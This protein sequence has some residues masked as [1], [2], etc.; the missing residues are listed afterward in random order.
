V[1]QT[2]A[3][4]SERLL[5]PDAAA[6]VLD[7]LA[8]DGEAEAGPLRLVPHEV[9]DLAEPLEHRLAV[10]LRHAGPVVLDPDDEARPSLQQL[11]QHAPA[12]GRGEL[13][14]VREQV[15]HHL[16]QPVAVAADR[17]A[18]RLQVGRQRDPPLGGHPAGRGDALLDDLPQVAALDLPLHLP[19][20][21]L[22][23]VEHV[24]DQPG[25]PVRLAHD[26]LQEVSPLVLGEVGRVEQDLRERAD[27]GQRR[28]QLV[29]DGRDEL[30]LQL[31]ELAQA[32]VRVAQLRRGLLQRQ[33]LLLQPPA[34]LDDLRGLVQDLHQVAGADH[35]AAHHGAHHDPR[36]GGADR[37]RELALRE[38]DQ[39][40]VGRRLGGSARR[41]PR[42]SIAKTSLGPVAPEEA[43]EQL[44]Q[45]RDLRLAAPQPGGRGRRLPLRLP[46]LVDVDEQRR[47]QPLQAAL[48]ASS[49]PSTSRVPLRL[50]STGPRARPGRGRPGRTAPAAAAARSR[51]AG[52]DEAGVEQAR[53]A[54]TGRTSV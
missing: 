1:K 52:C 16:D 19:G 4:P 7:D 53:P 38:L 24:V 40:R 35:L 46:M 9:A 2:A 3:P 14:R 21:D 36:G 34:V 15:H 11:D 49:E 13:G 23:E 6:E 30:V 29:A 50:G 39:L 27:R 26:D 32:L 22:R 8:R 47:L 45:R 31:V 5:E 54:M 51:T 12:L 43:V 18:G 42:A 10:G 41:S 37:A 48:P 44:A 28:A 20:L 33:R 17:R 25:Q